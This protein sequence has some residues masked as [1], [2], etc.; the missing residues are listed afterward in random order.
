[1]NKG[2]GDAKYLSEKNIFLL[3]ALIAFIGILNAGYLAWSAL[4]GDAPTC[5]LNS[6]CDVVARSEY[7]KI[8][9]IPLATFGVFFYS[10]IFGFALWKI[11]VPTVSVVPFLLPLALLGFLLSLYFLYL[12]AFAIK[13]Y[14][15][16]CLFSLFDATVIF[17][18]TLYTRSKQKRQNNLQ[19][20]V[21]E[22]KE[23]EGA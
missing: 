4:I 14:C 18:A 10:M 2:I 15:E 1:M 9:G 21:H 5:F 7:S 13:A 8:F 20:E 3:V 23:G 12:Q 19:E 22:E 6:G 11:K 17:V 16:Y